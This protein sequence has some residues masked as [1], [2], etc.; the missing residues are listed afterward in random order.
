MTSPPYNPHTQFYFTYLNVASVSLSYHIPFL[1]SFTSFNKLQL[2]WCNYFSFFRGQGN[3]YIVASSS[4]VTTKLLLS[5]RYY[6]LLEV[7]AVVVNDWQVVCHME[8]FNHL[9]LH[10]RCLVWEVIVTSVLSS[11]LELEKRRARILWWI[12]YTFLRTRP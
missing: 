5:F 10:S 12:H 8:C 3:F 6:N 7:R 2:N 9:R 11:S 1:S 4:A